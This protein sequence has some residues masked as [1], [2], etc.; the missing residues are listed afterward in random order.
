MLFT[1]EKALLVKLYYKN[2]ESAFVAL[3]AYRY[4]KGMRDSKGP[5]TSSA[6]NKIMKK[7]EA[8]SS[9]ASDQRSGS[10]STAVAVATTVEKTVQSK[11]VVAAHG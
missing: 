1:V 7:S 4:M 3:Q 6:L 11:S 8:T 2:S 9:L 5:I 10:T